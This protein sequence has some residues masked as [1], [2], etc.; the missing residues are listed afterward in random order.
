M[1]YRPVLRHAWYPQRGPEPPQFGTFFFGLNR[2]LREK[3]ER[4]A[5][6]RLHDGAAVELHRP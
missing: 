5:N 2:P 6:G 1:R 3:V 4:R